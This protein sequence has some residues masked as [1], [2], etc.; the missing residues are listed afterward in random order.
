MNIRVPHRIFGARAKTLMVVGMV[1][2][3]LP[4]LGQA[5]TM[6]GLTAAEVIARGEERFR[7]L[8][9]YECVVEIEARQ[10]ARV[11][12]GEG[13]FWFKQP[14]LLRLHVIRGSGKG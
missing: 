4:S 10:G 6:P 11:E 9:D 1:A 7:K 13:Q 8:T 12:S 14:R 3:V 5:A 2:L